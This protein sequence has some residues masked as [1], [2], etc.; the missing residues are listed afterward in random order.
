MSKESVS[1]L[2]SCDAWESAIERSIP[3]SYKWGCMIQL[4]REGFGGTER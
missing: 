2:R 4:P 1:G 3:D